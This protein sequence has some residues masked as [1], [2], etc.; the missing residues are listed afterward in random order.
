[1]QS[2]SREATEGREEL[3]LAAGVE[4]RTVKKKE[5]GKASWNKWTEEEWKRIVA[6]TCACRTFT[7]TFLFKSQQSCIILA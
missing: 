3:F 4:G 7:I 1:M 5:S 2:W 6:K